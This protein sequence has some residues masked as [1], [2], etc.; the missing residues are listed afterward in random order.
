MPLGYGSN[1]GGL[2]L[3]EKIPYLQS[4]G[5]THIELM[6]VHAFDE[7]DVPP[8]TAAKGLRNYWGY[9]T[10]SFFSPHPAYCVAAEAGKQRQEFREMVKAL[11]KAG[12]GVIL[13][14]VYN[15]TAEGN[16][17]GPH[18]NFKGF[19]NETFYH[20]DVLDK[21]LYRDYTG[22]GNTVNANHP[23]VTQYILESLEYWV[24]EMHVD[25]F[26]FD[27]AST[28]TRGE[29]GAPL[30]NPPVLWAIE[31]SESLSASKIIAEAWDAAGLY[32]VGTFPGYRW[33]E[34]NGRY[35]DCL[36]RF[37][38]G[39]TGLTGEMATRIAGSSDLYQSN[40]RLPIN[41]INFVTCHDGFTLWDLVSYNQ[42]HN[43]ANGEGNRDGNN[44]NLSWNC[45]HEGV[46]DNW[47][48]LA[49]R[50]RQARNLMAIQ[51]LSQGVP[52]LL[53][54]DEMLRTQDGNNNTW[55]QDNE[56]GWIDW[57]MAK[58]NRDMLRF[59]R[60]MI[61]LRRRHPSLQ[62]RHF[63]QGVPRMG[64]HW[65]D[66]RWFDPNLEDPDWNKGGAGQLAFML[67]DSVEGES[68]LFV[69]LNMANRALEFRVPQASGL[70]WL[71]AVDTSLAA[72]EDILPRGEQPAHRSRSYKMGPRSVAVLESAAPL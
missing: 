34:W 13:D 62:R 12:I 17:N 27:L 61:A 55:C 69:M 5:I 2:G 49:L 20:L 52:M 44:D 66:I 56:L 32:Q 41:S 71:R 53:A 59:T 65:P 39:D 30:A 54:G 68:L 16:N 58:R 9:S 14:V 24:R 6:P 47:K 15:H 63:F 35:R 3:I 21:Q 45:G 51:L 46:T 72:P 10:H 48:I 25:G 36:R 50:H 18:I 60:E 26:R 4:L 31:L 57:E 67:G 38:R 64:S 28:L 19:G 22:C 43:L 33:S 37:V 70:R 11:H 23:F 42:K 1:P 40:M 7:Q 29:D 8:M